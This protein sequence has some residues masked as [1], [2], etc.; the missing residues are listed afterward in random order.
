MMCIIFYFDR[1]TAR[2]APYELGD[3]RYVTLLE[4]AIGLAIGVVDDA[5]DLVARKG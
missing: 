2:L 3:V 1:P 4:L 5:D